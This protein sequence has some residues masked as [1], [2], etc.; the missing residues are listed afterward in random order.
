MACRAIWRVSPAD[1]ELARLQI[2]SKRLLLND[3]I[4]SIEGVMF[5]FSCISSVCSNPNTSKGQRSNANVGETSYPCVSFFIV[6]QPN[7]K[8]DDDTFFAALHNQDVEP[9][10]RPIRVR[11]GGN[12]DMESAARQ[13]FQTVKD[14]DNGSMQQMVDASNQYCY[15]NAPHSSGESDDEDEGD[16][17]QFHPTHF[18]THPCSFVLVSHCGDVEELKEALRKLESD[19]LVLDAQVRDECDKGPSNTACDDTIA[20]IR[21]IER[22]MALCNHALYRGEIYGRPD[23]ARISYVRLMDVSSYLNK[24]LANDALNENL[25]KNFITI[26]RFLAHPACEIVEQIRFDL[27]LIEVSNGF[28]FSISDR[29]FLPD[30]IHESMIGKVSPRAYVPYECSA[31]PQPHH[32]REGILN[33][34]PERLVRVQFLNKF[35][36]CLLAHKMP[37][38]TRKLVVTGPRDSGKTSWAS[39]F[40]RIIPEE[41][42][43][44][45]TN[46]RQFS[47][48]MITND[49][50]LVFIDEWSENTMSAELAKKVL[51]GGWMVTA[52]K[53][54]QPRRVNSHSPFYIT[55]NQVPDFGAEAENVERR[56]HIFPTQSL[57]TP[58]PGIDQWLFENAMH[59]IAWMA[60]QINTHR[61]FIPAA[62]LWYEDD[63]NVRHMV[64]SHNIAAQWTRTD[65]VKITEADMEPERQHVNRGGPDVAIHPDFL[66]EA[67][68]RRLAR[69]RR[70]A[71]P[72]SDSSSPENSSENVAQEMETYPSHAS[73]PPRSHTT[74]EHGSQTPY[75]EHGSQTPDEEHGSQTPHEEH[76]SQTPD[77]EHGSQTPYE[78]H[79]S[80]TPD[81][82]N[83]SQT[84]D[85]EDASQ[86]PDEENAS[87]TPEEED[88][89]KTPDEEHGSQTPDEEDAFQTPET[90]ALPL[91]EEPSTSTGITHPPP[92]IWSRIKNW[93]R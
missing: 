21:K 90:V 20:T 88:G 83:A 82:E 89:S 50:Q 26:Q 53:H 71:R 10:I 79:A 46:E 33:S 22:V 61:D 23:G 12:H 37:Q 5:Y 44:S 76:G 25:A 75:E 47:A 48:A 1:I 38:K 70:R 27:N 67:R 78:E 15:D 29:A 84:P 91:N 13:L 64:P 69:K 31:A 49:T 80:Q 60:D 35:Y 6:Y 4:A 73:Q 19:G 81:E 54:S 34:F 17:E 32:F 59:C 18:P 51:Q 62:E 7:E 2:A 52:V 45:I 72:L 55:T 92:T 74:E 57:P 39:I 14:H 68:S 36:Q 16:A 86:T 65:I 9:E 43:A 63:E 24:L 3:A 56:I 77:E 40:R 85:E 66:A 41:H 42:I 58:T 93:W 87:Q 28:C 30:P 11:N 8:C